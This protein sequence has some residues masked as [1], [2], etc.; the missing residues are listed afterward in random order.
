MEQQAA[1][2]RLEN[3]NRAGGGEDKSS[4]R[5]S[6]GRPGGRD[7][8]GK[9]RWPLRLAA[10]KL[11]AGFRSGEPTTLVPSAAAIG[12]PQRQADDTS[13]SRGLALREGEMLLVACSA[14]PPHRGIVIYG[15]ADQSGALLPVAWAC[16][17]STPLLDGGGWPAATR[18]HVV[19][20]SVPFT[21]TRNQRG[22]IGT[23]PVQEVAGRRRYQD[24]ATAHCIRR[25]TKSHLVRLLARQNPQPAAGEIVGHRS[26]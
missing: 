20:L 25:A 24:G 6:A 7:Y 4:S 8:G 21:T 14:Q 1:S 3:G 11:I 10:R 12:W 15:S 2:S 17:H 5:A 19:R 13:A 22:R 9:G 23:I 26:H 16:A 18:W